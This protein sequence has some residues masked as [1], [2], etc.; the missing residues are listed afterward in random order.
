MSTPTPD[1]PDLAD[2]LHPLDYATLRAAQRL[3]ALDPDIRLALSETWWVALRLG[4]QLDVTR[5][6]ELP[7]DPFGAAAMLSLAEDITP[8]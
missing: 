2:I 7:A 5:P 6:L 8:F 4:L 1:K 3:A